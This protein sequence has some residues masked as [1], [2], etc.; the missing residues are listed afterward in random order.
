VLAAGVEQRRNRYLGWVR[1]AQGG[2]GERAI[3]TLAY[4]AAEEGR[5]QEAP[6]AVERQGAVGQVED[7][8]GTMGYGWV[9]EAAGRARCGTCVQ[10]W[11][12][13]GARLRDEDFRE[14]AVGLAW[15]WARS[16]TTTPTRAPGL[17]STTRAA[18]SAAA[19]VRARCRDR[20]RVTHGPRHGGRFSTRQLPRRASS[21]AI[22][23]G[24]FIE[25]SK[26][27]VAG[28]VDT[29]PSIWADRSSRLVR[30]VFDDA[31]P[32]KECL[33]S[34]VSAKRVS[35]RQRHSQM[36]RQ[37]SCA[38]AAAPAI[39]RRSADSGESRMTRCQRKRSFWGESRMS[40]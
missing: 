6:H 39:C 34:S 33:A 13:R 40:L 28:R 10:R 2:V 4:G 21:S 32:A 35:I 31:E 22:L 19:R 7:Q 24:D 37:A 27:N 11:V 38:A 23:R 30:S 9:G 12:R 18:H 36:R 16:A 25:P 5:A 17:A 15:T 14:D 1:L 20:R 29:G 26:E 8:Q 3:G